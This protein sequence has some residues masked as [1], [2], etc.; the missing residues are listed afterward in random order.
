MDT[1]RLIDVQR[2]PQGVRKEFFLLSSH[3]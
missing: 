2:V 1:H 3:Y